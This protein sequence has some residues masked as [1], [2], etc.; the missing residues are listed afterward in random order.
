[1]KTDLL[2]RAR[3]FIDLEARAVA[4]LASVL[5]ERFTRAIELLLHVKGRVVTTG[6]GKAGLVAHKVSATLASTGTP[7]LFLHPAEAIHGDLG[8]VTGDDVVI[9]FS[10]KGQTEEVLRIIPYFKHRRV[11]LIAVTSN[12]ASELARQSDVALVLAIDKEACPHN[13]APTSSTTA[14]MALGDTL[15]LV[16]LEARGF[17]PE[18][19]AVFHPGGSLGKRL[20]TKVADLMH[21]GD[22]NPVVREDAPLL[23]AITV[24]TSKKLAAT[25]VAAADGRLVGFFSDGD[26]RRYL[27]QGQPDMAR[28]MRD[29]MTR[30]PKV[31]PPDM[32][33]VR[34][35]EILREHKIIELPVVDADHRPV[36]MIHL[37]DITRAGIA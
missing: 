28:P 35:L 31:V 17:T 33:A 18:D 9:A 26:L 8:M 15:A 23:E 29:L 19:Y 2:A 11:P 27:M 34:A 12:A 36:G 25:S 32:M 30:S 1:M 16:L 21:A 3:H 20:L 24:M 13:L 7:A 22:D 37:H 4:G 14:M 10:H 6:M 5:D